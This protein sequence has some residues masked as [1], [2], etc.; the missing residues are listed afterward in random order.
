VSRS[1]VL[2]AAVDLGSTL[3]KSALLRSDG[4]L[5]ARLS[6]PAPPLGGAGE[7]REGD[8]SAFACVADRLLDDLARAVP[9]GTALGLATQRSS[10]LLWDCRTGE[11]LTPLVS[12]QDRR[13]AS[14][15]ARHQDAAPEVARR[16]G[17]V[18]TAHY[19]G[20][21]LAALVEQSREWR[22]LLSR[23][24]T[25]LGTL[26]CWL[27]WRRTDGRAHE[28]DRTMAARTAMLDLADATWSDELLALYGVRRS[29]LPRVRSS[30]GIGVPLDGGLVLRASIADQAAS[31]LPL[32][33]EHGDV[34]SVTLGTGAFVLRPL[35]RREPPSPGYLLAPILSC[36]TG[37]SLWAHEGTVNG[38]GAAVD[39][40]GPGPTELPGSD[41]TPDA[42]CLP[43]VAGLGSPWWRPEVGLTFSDAAASLDT[44]NQRRVVLEGL[45]FR[46]R[47]VIADLGGAPR[48]RRVLLAGGLA[49]EPF[50]AQ[51][52]AA[53]L[54][55]P[56]ECVEIHDAGL[57]GAA[58]L[59]AGRTT[60][61][62]PVTRAVQP[63]GSGAYLPAKYGRWRAWADSVL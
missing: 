43:D 46:V 61:G 2:A 49:R 17:L 31:V 12:W 58:G 57:V 4:A 54:E 35:A 19:V 39:R 15:C 53:L 63:S 16:T 33:G 38:A 34:L 24:S 40:F 37:K 1:A 59:A 51:G 27:I 14:W 21:K 60:F 29:I 23:E 22:E 11:P 9:C 44:A 55:R 5:E 8:A 36:P 48:D 56:I 52:L 42:W 13:A 28:V 6:L 26:D 25:L 30:T 3:L 7:I 47:Q 62:D 10:F 50:V 41:P 18:L 20:P 45:L 32:L